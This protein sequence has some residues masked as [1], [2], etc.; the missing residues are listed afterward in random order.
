MEN[1]R[2]YSLIIAIIFATSCSSVPKRVNTSFYNKQD[3]PFVKD[4]DIAKSLLEKDIIKKSGYKYNLVY[5]NV[6]E[7]NVKDEKVVRDFGNALEKYGIIFI[8]KEQSRAEKR[9][10]ITNILTTLKSG[11]EYYDSPFLIAFDKE[12]SPYDIVSFSKVSNECTKQFLDRM[13]N[14]I[15]KNVGGTEIIGSISKTKL[16]YCKYE[17]KLYKSAEKIIEFIVGL[18]KSKK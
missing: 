8:V 9:H 12:G 17:P 13:E 10:F 1:I 7:S 16:K 11:Y 18:V 15:H 4:I 14:K 3:T 2:I 5:I 6:K